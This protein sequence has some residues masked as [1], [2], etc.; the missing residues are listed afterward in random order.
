[1]IKIN[2]AKLA[3]KLIL[4]ILIITIITGFACAFATARSDQS[5]TKLDFEGTEYL[6]I[7]LPLEMWGEGNIMQARFYKEADTFGT[8]DGIAYTGYNV[9]YLHNKFNLKTG[10]FL[11]H[12]EVTMFISWNGLEGS[13]YGHLH[14]KGTAGVGPFDGKYT[15]QGAGDFEGMKLFGIVWLIGGPVNGMSGTIFIPN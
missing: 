10:E 14:A 2:R 3:P 12:G 4:S 11:A 9:L 13:F 8:I 6:T 7:W 5:S 15:L 1:L